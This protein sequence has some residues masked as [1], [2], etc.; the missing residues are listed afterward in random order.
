MTPEPDQRVF[1]PFCPHGRNTIY[2]PCPQC[3]TEH[4]EQHRHR[5]L[6]EALEQISENQ[7][8][9]AELLQVLLDRTR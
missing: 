5:V 3:A 4:R 9:T 1:S 2:G 7:R 6:V 8:R